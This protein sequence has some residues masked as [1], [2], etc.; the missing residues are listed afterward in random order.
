MSE[1]HNIQENWHPNFRIES[2]LP[3]TRVIRTHAIS[4]IV[5]YTAVLIVAVVILQREYQSYELSKTIDRLEQQIQS[6]SPADKSRL[7]KSKQFRELASNVQELQ[8]F[9]RTPLM[10]HDSVVALARLKP[11]ELTFTRLELSE[12]VVQVKVGKKSQPKVVFKLSISGNV[13]ELSVLTQFK[14]KLEESELLNLSE[15]GYTV[16]INEDIEQRD[17]DTGIV[18]FQ[19]SILLET[20]KDKSTI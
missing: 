18:P 7:E 13:K 4:K 15:S 10:V 20:A 6:A 11:K 19:L 8:R 12:L 1:R 9:F 3:D 16:I 2:T 5:L 14:R 17:T